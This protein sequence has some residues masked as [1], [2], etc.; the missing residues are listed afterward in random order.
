MEGLRNYARYLVMSSDGDRSD[1]PEMD[2]ML[3]FINVTQGD[4]FDRI[5]LTG[6]RIARRK[7]PRPETVSRSAHGQALWSSCKPRRFNEKDGRVFYE[8]DLGITG[9]AT[10]LL[11]QTEFLRHRSIAI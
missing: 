4:V 1:E 11:R 10:R 7:S 2:F 8:Y 6:I 9:D 5:S 3:F